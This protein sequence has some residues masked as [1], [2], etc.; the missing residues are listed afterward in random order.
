[1]GSPKSQG[2]DEFIQALFCKLFADLQQR[3]PKQ[4]RSLCRDL[5]TFQSRFASEGLSFATKTLPRLGKLFDAALD[6]GKLEA[7]PAFSKAKGSRT[8]PAFLQGMY[9][10]LFDRDGYLVTNNAAAVSDLRQLFYLV[11][12][13][14]VPYS[15]EDEQRVI[16]AFLRNEEE[17]LHVDLSSVDLS[18]EK[19]LMEEI[20]EGFTPKDIIPRH[21]PGAVATGEKLEQKWRFQ[22]LFSQIHQSYPYY[23]YFIVGG[24][25]ELLDRLEWYKSLKREDVGVAKVVLVPK[26]SRGPRLIS[27]EPLEYQ[28]IQQGLNHKLVRHLESHRLTRGQINFQDQSVNRDLA[29]ESSKHHFYCT[30]DLKDASDRVSLDLVRELI[31]EPLI[32]YF[33]AVRSHATLLPDGRIVTLRK[34]APMGSAVCFSVEALC[35]WVIC[36]A[37]VM[38][39]LP[40]GLQEV[41]RHVYVYG[42]DIIVPTVAYDDVVSAL[43]SVG[44][45]VNIAKCCSNGDFRESCGMDAFDGVDVTPVKISACWSANSSDGSC[46]SS[47]AAYANEFARRGYDGVATSLRIAIRKVYRFLPC[48]TDSD[49]FPC[50][51][52][53]T[54]LEAHARNCAM[55]F[56]FRSNPDFQRL[57]YRV[58]VLVPK[59][60]KTTLEGWPRLL[61]QQVGLAGERPD[62]VVH[63]RSTTLRW[64]WSRI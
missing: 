38:R 54:R 51:V 62:E 37:A 42:D 28:W 56:R 45:V 31:P 58:K 3:W 25:H 6:S 1:M 26:D 48:S 44:L 49:S 61:R 16:D 15:P 4:S 52:V 5:E 50:E 10:L 55:G 60:T 35:F 14:K 53:A 63:P 47:Y 41:A 19:R 18:V 7:S 13:L 24:S 12:K 20:L 34:Y 32:R 8:I 40:W 23:D 30:L 27:C 39:K 29:L 9:S 2:L 64:R 36:V 43:H 46:L 22:R 57:E 21:G 17:L 11:Y 59:R 33:E